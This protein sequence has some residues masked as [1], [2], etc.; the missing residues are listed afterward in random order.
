VSQFRGSL[1]FNIRDLR[2]LI[3]DDEAKPQIGEPLLSWES[4]KEYGL[5]RSEVYEVEKA[6]TIPAGYRVRLKNVKQDYVDISKANLQQ[7][8][9]DI[10][11]KGLLKFSFAHCITAHKS[12][13]S[14]WDNV[15]VLAYDHWFKFEDHW[16]WLYTAC[17]RAK[18]H[19]TI[20]I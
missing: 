14:E 20:V 6:F 15:V 5:V 10:V 3:G 7:Q 12:Q 9:T 13:G 18:K 4:K 11:V 8:K 19:L 16:H 17:T 1:H 2:G